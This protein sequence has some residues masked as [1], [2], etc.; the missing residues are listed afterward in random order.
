MVSIEIVPERDPDTIHDTIRVPRDFR[1]EDFITTMALPRDS[2]P[3]DRTGPF[4]RRSAPYELVEVVEQA[5]ATYGVVD[6]EPSS[7]ASSSDFTRR[8]G[9]SEFAAFKASWS[10]HTGWF[11]MTNDSLAMIPEDEEFAPAPAA[12]SQ[13]RLYALA[14]AIGVLALGLGIAIAMLAL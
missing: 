3:D 8:H 6:E 9:T 5:P 2:V 11:K 7:A 4:V 12:P 13:L 1:L 14:A 10:C